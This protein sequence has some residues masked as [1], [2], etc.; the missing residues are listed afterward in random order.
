MFALFIIR[1]GKENNIDLIYFDWALSYHTS[2]MIFFRFKSWK[3][4]V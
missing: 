2:F 3:L 4:D 1:L